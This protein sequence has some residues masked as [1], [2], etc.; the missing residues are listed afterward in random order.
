[1]INILVNSEDTVSFDIFLGINKEQK[2]IVSA[3]K[4]DLVK[5]SIVEE[6]II[7]YCVTVKK[8]NYRDNVQIASGAVTTDG[9]IVKIDPS[10]ARYERFVLL[11]KSWTFVDGEGNKIPATRESIDRLNPDIAVVIA[12]KISEIF[13]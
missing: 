3:N 6:E 12:D 13:D 7:T 2:L 4:A 11:L 1:M 8:P 5:E 9:E 10:A